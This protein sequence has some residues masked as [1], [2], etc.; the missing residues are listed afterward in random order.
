MPERAEEP[1]VDVTEAVGDRQKKGATANPDGGCAVLT[2]S[3]RSA[4]PGTSGKDCG[5]P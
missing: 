2:A 4:L 3:G 1:P 5:G